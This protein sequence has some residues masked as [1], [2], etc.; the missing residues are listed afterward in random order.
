MLN[1]CSYFDKNYLSKFLVLRDS[2]I[3]NHCEHNFYVLALDDFTYQFLNENNFDN[4]I[5][6]SVQELEE[7]YAELIKIKRSRNLIEYY[8]TLSPYLPI[9]FKNKFNLKKLNYLDVDILFFRNP[10]LFYNKLS[11]YSIILVKQNYKK[12]YGLYNVGWISYN[13]LNS[14]TN[15]ILND[16]KMKCSEW[17]YDKVE[18]NRYADQKYLDYWPSLSKSLVA[19]DPE[20]SMISPWDTFPPSY[21]KNSVDFYSYHFHGLKFSKNYFISGKSIYHF[22]FHRKFIENFYLQYIYLLNNKLM[23]YKLQFTDTQSLRSDAASKKEI[24]PK[25]INLVK[26]IKFYLFAI[27]RFDFYIIK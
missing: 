7:E 18:K 6:S 5:I 12:K 25:I 26:K 10:Q 20:F 8:F 13:F 2:L 24:F 4:V 23:R 3:N 15:K 9:F 16:W 21:I 19:I 17:C 1:F 27:L 11:D 22:N 14:D